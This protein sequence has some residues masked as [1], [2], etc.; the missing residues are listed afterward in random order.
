M[1]WRTINGT[2]DKGFRWKDVSSLI[3]EICR[4]FQVWVEA[5]RFDVLFRDIDRIDTLLLSE[6]FKSSE[7]LSVN[8]RNPNSTDSRQERRLT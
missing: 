2:L 6:K 1:R 8:P 3:V 7:R 4:I 5:G